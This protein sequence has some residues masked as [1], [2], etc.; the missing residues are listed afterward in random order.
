M[1]AGPYMPLKLAW[2]K[3]FRRAMPPSL[4]H[5]HS[6]PVVASR[7]PNIVSNES[8]SRPELGLPA[9]RLML[10]PLDIGERP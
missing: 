2:L 4:A 6:V 1:G 7:L 3:G 9:T 8:E 5:H 10:G